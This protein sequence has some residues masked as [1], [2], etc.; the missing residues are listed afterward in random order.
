METV[1]PTSLADH[2]TVVDAM[3]AELNTL[4]ASAVAAPDMPVKAFLDEGM[5][6]VEAAKQHLDALVRAGLSEALIITLERTVLALQSAQIL[7]NT[8][9][10]MGRSE[11]MSRLIEKAET[12][13]S[14]LLAASDLAL[15][16]DPDALA[17]LSAIREGEGLADLVMDLGDLAV[18]ITDRKDLYTAVNLDPDDLAQSAAG[19]RNDLQSGLA[20]EDV[21]KTLSGYKDTR[22][23]CFVLAKQALQEVRAFAKFA[24]RDDTTNVRRGLF[25]STYTRN[26]DRRSR[27]NRLETALNAGNTS[28]ATED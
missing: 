18:L 5:T 19:F 15:R 24:F 21:A 3:R 25:F 12:V 9:R 27:R 14:Y 17:R 26:R 1:K 8:E 20:E 7:W 11:V 6:A 22:D 13:R 16:N 23:R 2:K 28:Q 4:P 10:G